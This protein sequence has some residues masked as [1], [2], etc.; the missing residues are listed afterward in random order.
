MVT[1]VIVS[2]E[3]PTA[4]LRP[5]DLDELLSLCDTLAVISER[6]GPGERI[7][8]H[9][10]RVDE[11]ILPRGPAPPPRAASRRPAPVRAAAG[12]L[13]VRNRHAAP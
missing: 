6:I 4:T 1:T 2:G 10:H 7:P 3:L 13:P 12:A 5:G 9:I 8:L 11:V